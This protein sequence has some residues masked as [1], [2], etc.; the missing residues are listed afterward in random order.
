[1][2]GVAT[3]GEPGGVRPTEEPGGEKA[4]LPAP[5]EQDHAANLMPLPNDDLVS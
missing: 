5:R 4:F 3:V 2:R 1:M